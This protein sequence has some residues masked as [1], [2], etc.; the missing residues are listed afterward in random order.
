RLLLTVGR[1]IERKG[2]AWFVREVLPNLSPNVV[3]AVAGAGPEAGHIRA[4]AQ[5]AGV[6]ARVRLL[7]RLPD[8]LLAAAYHAADLF[9]MP[10]IPVL[11]DL[12]G[13]G[14]VALEASASGLPVVAAN[15]E[16]ITEA[17]QNERNGF[18][19]LPRAADAYVETLQRLL[20]L[21]QDQLRSIGKAFRDFTVR[22]YSWSRTAERYI[23]V[24]SQIARSPDALLSAA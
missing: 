1:L 17:V 16:G 2:V 3:Y 12:E 8:A 10:N 19:I 6:D 7:G 22:E 20:S 21:P 24:I 13:F 5:Q 4:A 9:V 23:E 14:L 11:G 15:L 18:L